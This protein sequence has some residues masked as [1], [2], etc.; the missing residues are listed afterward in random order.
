MK[1]LGIICVLVCF[2]VVNTYALTEY[3]KQQLI[4]KFTSGKQLSASDLMKLQALKNEMETIQKTLNP[5]DEKTTEKDIKKEDE[6]NTKQTSNETTLNPLNI[7]EKLLKGQKPPDD[8][9]LPEE[10][11]EEKPTFYSRYYFNSEKYE[12]ET[13]LDELKPFGYDFFDSPS[14][15]APLN[16][17]PV[18]DDYV[19]GPG[20][21]IRLV[22]WGGVSNVYD[23]EV[24]QNGTITT[25]EIGSINVAGMNY[26]T[27]KN[28]LG[29]GL[30]A[31]TN[32]EISFAKLKTI[33][34][35]ITGDARS[36]GSYTLSGLTTLV[37][38]IFAAGGPSYTG[39]MRMIQLK[40]AGRIIRTFDLYDFLL[41]GDAS[42]DSVLQPG[43]AIYFAPIQNIVATTGNIR[44][45][46]LY[47]MKDGQTLQD[48]IDI[49]GGL[50]ASADTTNVYI[51]QF[52]KNE[53][54]KVVDIKPEV[55][56]MKKV[57]LSDGDIVR[58]YPTPESF[59]N[60][61]SVTLTGYVAKPRKFAFISGMKVSDVITKDVLLPDTYLQYAS[62]ER[63][64]Y[65]ENTKEMMPI[66]IYDIVYK[67]DTQADILI[68]EE[69]VIVLYSIGELKDTPPVFIMGEVRT[70]GIYPY[71][72][73]MTVFDMMHIAGGLTNIANLAN[74]EFVALEFN[75]NEMQPPMITTINV[76]EILE[77]PHD[78]TVN[79]KVKP[80]SKLFIRRLA[81]FRENV[82]ITL[83]GEVK[84]PGVYYA[85]KT[86]RLHDIIER[87]GGFTDNAYVR[88]A[89]FSR[90]RVKE[91]QQK[92]LQSIIT[93]L[94]KN[95][96]EL[97]SKS[98]Q[99]PEMQN[100]IPV[101][102][103]RIEKIKIMEVSGRM[104]IRLPEKLEDLKKSPYNIA[105]EDGD[106]L[107]IPERS[108]EIVVM[109]EVYNPN[110]FVYNSKNGKIKH[111]LAM[112]GGPSS[113]GDIGRAFVVK[114]NGTVIS[115]Y[116]IDEESSSSS[117][118]SSGFLNARIFPGDTII[119]PTA[120]QKVPFIKNMVDWTT[121]LYQLATT[122]KITSDIWAK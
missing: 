45:P 24:N 121:V 119:V 79:F 118:L 14:T 115:P 98:Q 109:G 114:A 77:K 49:A 60:K 70:P 83:K 16:N 46:A 120:T 21:K 84:Y 105:I 27:L 67:R 103:E 11:P 104:V 92:N 57:V 82:A 1:S 95:L 15:Y 28:T 75:D 47:E 56:D 30:S 108:N 37:N 25:P 122:I 110:V 6:D 107:T 42:K 4:E 71:T 99:Y 3:E 32:V 86:D 18:P 68:H 69:D 53:G 89:Y 88:A 51:E 85:R 65:P 101:Y 55:T 58:I 112:T 7:A 117:F 26:R 97:M 8:T 44:R 64:K 41:F 5:D 94:E 38:A 90:L 63:R 48:L 54:R 80:F 31:G 87:A 93:S 116:Y 39:S 29:S 100:Y 111:Y 10:M 96:E 23:I 81:D 13:P 78:S 50:T 9:T 40:R 59:N 20:D 106:E 61:N 72:D 33:R 102:K 22:F 62:I 113:E 35:F 36:P 76:R 52:R 66:N 19:I 91:L 74:A 12:Y 17:I 73:G 2:F 34:V 43:D